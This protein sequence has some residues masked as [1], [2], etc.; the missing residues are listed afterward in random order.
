MSLR[1]ADPLLR[2][3]MS[4]EKLS[5]EMR[6]LRIKDLVDRR[7][8]GAIRFVDHVTQKVVRRPM[9]INAPGL[10]FF[11]NLCQFQI[12][13]YARGIEMHLNLMLNL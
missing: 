12:I 7:Y 2:R 3:A 9:N 11:T 13:S 8:L 6:Q 5:M 1:K 4:T 10:N